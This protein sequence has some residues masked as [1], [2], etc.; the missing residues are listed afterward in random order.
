MRV[1][2]T[3]STTPFGTYLRAEKF[4]F[5]FALF[6][7]HANLCT[8]ELS[9]LNLTRHG[10]RSTAHSLIRAQIEKSEHT[11]HSARCGLCFCMQTQP[12]LIAG[13]HAR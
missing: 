7:S 5:S 2:Y 9:N 10:T 12:E 8:Y 6:P 4:R 11:T 13:S 1:P 3:N